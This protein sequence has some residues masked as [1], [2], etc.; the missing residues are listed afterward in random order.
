[1]KKI[2]L[3]FVIL[4]GCHSFAG[5]RIVGNGGVGVEIGNNIYMLDLYERSIHNDVYYPPGLIPH[6]FIT[7]QVEETFSITNLS[8]VPVKQLIYK[9]EEI[10]TKYP[11]LAVAMLK[12]MQVLD[13]SLVGADLIALEDTKTPLDGIMLRQVAIRQ[14]SRIFISD[15]LWNKLDANNRVAL[16]IHEILYYMAEPLSRVDSKSTQKFYAQ[17]ASEV[18]AMTGLLLSRKF[19]RDGVRYPPMRTGLLLA[20]PSA[21]SSRY[22]SAGTIRVSLHHSSFSFDMNDFNSASDPALL[23]SVSRE[24]SALCKLD[25]LKEGYYQSESELYSSNVTVYLRNLQT[26]R[27]DYYQ[28]PDLD[29]QERY[30][31]I[32]EGSTFESEGPGKQF[33]NRPKPA[34]FDYQRCVQALEVQVSDV[35]KKF[36]YKEE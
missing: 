13:W 31:A 21:P 4:M 7:A 19:S 30:V 32:L 9:M 24:I 35:L 5:P 2:I 22:Q 33:K 11:Y 26:H 14:E 8:A 6:K 34:V 16:I 36:N 3:G 29:R 27:E 18:R 20:P 1:M 23:A 10:Y 28:S 25:W 12:A 15:S 17:S